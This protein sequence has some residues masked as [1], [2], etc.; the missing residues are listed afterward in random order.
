[1]AVPPAPVQVPSQWPLDPSITSIASVA[2]D[3]GDNEMI[4][5]AV[6][7]HPGICLTV[8]ENPGKPQHGAKTFVLPD[9]VLSRL[10]HLRVLLCSLVIPNHSDLLR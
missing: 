3:K 9:L 8:E 6:H 10:L 4:P 5:G 1:M 7:R 2:N